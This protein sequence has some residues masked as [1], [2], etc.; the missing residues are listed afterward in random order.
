MANMRSSLAGIGSDSAGQ[1]VRSDQPKQ[2]KLK[3]PLSP[4]SECKESSSVKAPTEGILERKLVEWS[5]EI[6]VQDISA[7]CFQAEISNHS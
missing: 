7:R 4:R 2:E 1:N 5:E 3:Y 6:D